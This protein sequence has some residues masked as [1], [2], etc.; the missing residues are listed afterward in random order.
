MCMLVGAVFNRCV[1]V[2]MSP[3]CVLETC[4][5]VQCLLRF[6]VL[7]HMSV[8]YCAVPLI[9]TCLSSHH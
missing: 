5:L 8:V 2:L 9:F 3:G 1:Q 6:V 7:F 4:G